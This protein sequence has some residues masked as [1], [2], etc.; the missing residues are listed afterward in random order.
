MSDS[1]LNESWDRGSFL[2]PNHKYNRGSI[3]LKGDCTV[4]LMSA[5]VSRI[6]LDVPVQHH[7]NRTIGR[8]SYCKY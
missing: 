4:V 5:V 2:K 6:F 1:A 3:Q 8:D 7:C